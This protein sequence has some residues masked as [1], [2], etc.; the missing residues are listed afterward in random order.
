MR[1]CLSLPSRFPVRPSRCRGD[2]SE[3]DVSITQQG[4]VQNLGSQIFLPRWKTKDEAVTR[5]LS[6]NCAD[7]CSTSASPRYLSECFQP[8]CEGPARSLCPSA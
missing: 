8:P 4:R 2:G 1:Q 3:A 6:T 5:S 7:L